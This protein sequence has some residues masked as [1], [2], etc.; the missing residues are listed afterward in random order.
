MVHIY[1]FRRS[2]AKAKT[3]FA[4]LLMVYLCMVLAPVFREG[5]GLTVRIGKIASNL[6]VR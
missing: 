3:M 4:F 1:H 6:V 5:E 2:V